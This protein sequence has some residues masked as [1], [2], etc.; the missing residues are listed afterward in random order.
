MSVPGGKQSE[1]SCD[2]GAPGSFKEQPRSYCGHSRENEVRWK[3]GSDCKRL[4]ATVSVRAAFRG[5]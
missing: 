3:R 4:E 5:R 2:G 1:L